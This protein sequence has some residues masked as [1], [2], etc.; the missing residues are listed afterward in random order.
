M[1]RASVEKASSQMV[2]EVADRCDVSGGMKMR[3]G[4]V[5]GEVAFSLWSYTETWRKQMT[6]NL[7]TTAC[8]AR[9][10]SGVSGRRKYENTR[11][12]ALAT[13]TRQAK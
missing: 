7:S 10:Y 13:E 9:R 8:L 5:P 2:N 3:Y 4:G 6:Y 12:H 11:Q 1:G